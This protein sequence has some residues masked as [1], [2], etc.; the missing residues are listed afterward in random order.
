MSRSS[1][2]L[3]VVHGVAMCGVAGSLVHLGFCLVLLVQPGVGGGQVDLAFFKLFSRV[4]LA[5]RL[6]VR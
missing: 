3:T 6:V 5:V 1:I 2:H 4:F